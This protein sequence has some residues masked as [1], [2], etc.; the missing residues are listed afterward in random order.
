MID[1]MR[2][3]ASSRSWQTR[4]VVGMILLGVVLALNQQPARGQGGHP[5]D[6]QIS[7]DLEPEVQLIQ[8]EGGTIMEIGI[9]GRI[10]MVKVTFE[11]A[12]SYYLIDYND[13]GEWDTPSFGLGPEV[14]SPQ[15]VLFE[16]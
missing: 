4:V 16:W 11:H 5:Q 12:P 2:L 6:S 13:D 1:S 14:V 9:D 8:P 15:W 3:G 10:Y 7:P